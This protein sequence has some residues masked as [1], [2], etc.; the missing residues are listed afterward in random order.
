MRVAI[1]ASRC[2]TACWSLSGP[3]NAV[4]VPA[5]ATAASIAAW[6]MPT[7]NAP[8]LGRN[9]SSVRIATRKPRSLLA[10]QLG[11][12][13][14]H[15][16]EDQAA[17]RV[18]ADHVEVLAAQAGPVG[19]HHERAHPARAGAWRGPGEDGVEVGLGRVGDPDLLAGQPPPGAVGFG[20]QRQRGGV[21]SGLGLGQRERRH[22]VPGGHR[23]QP[24]PDDLLPPGLQDRVGAEALQGQRGL[25]LGALRGQRLP[26]QAQVHRGGLPRRPP[27][28]DPRKQPGE[29]PEVAHGLDQLAVHL[30]RRPRLGQRTQLSGG[31]IPHPFGE[32][33]LLGR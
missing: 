31:E 7:A 26:Q 4:R 18:R 12:L 29:Q 14:R 9:R 19:G 27:A 28:G 25:R 13:H 20:P 21:G 32:I 23:G 8:T 17:D 5:C 3:P 11:R 1:S 6:A 16:V 15:P 30:A 24:A 33:L 10:E 2:E 22:R